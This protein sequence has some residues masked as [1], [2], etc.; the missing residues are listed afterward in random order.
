MMP[1]KLERIAEVINAEWE[2]DDSP[3]SYLTAGDYTAEIEVTEGGYSVVI[4]RGDEKMCAATMLTQEGGMSLYV[5]AKFTIITYMMATD[6]SQTACIPY[7]N[8]MP[9]VSF[10]E[11]C[12]TR[13]E[14]DKWFAETIGAELYAI[15]QRVANDEYD[16][17][18]QEEQTIF[19]SD[20]IQ[21]SDYGILEIF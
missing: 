12:Y 2:H 7:I 11:I 13:E 17:M 1:S 15:H 18:T 6:E 5:W 3:G 20:V 19:D 14:V 21:P 16:D 10:G 9:E 8:L 4:K